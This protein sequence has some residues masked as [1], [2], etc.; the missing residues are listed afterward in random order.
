MYEIVDIIYKII[1][2][3]MKYTKYI[4]IYVKLYIIYNYI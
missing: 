2:S 3:H 1:I 4:F